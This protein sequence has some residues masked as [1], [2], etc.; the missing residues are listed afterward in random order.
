MTNETYQNL[1]V[2]E[3]YKELPFNIYKNTEVAIK[4]L[5]NKLLKY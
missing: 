4:N 1:D 3:F 2:L 5:K